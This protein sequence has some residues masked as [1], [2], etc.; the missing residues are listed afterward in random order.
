MNNERRRSLTVFSRGDGRGGVGGRGGGGVTLGRR[1]R[2]L[3]V[4][5]LLRSLLLF[6]GFLGLVVVV[7]EI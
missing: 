6:L 2:H 3:L 7:V 4:D 1:R 5:F